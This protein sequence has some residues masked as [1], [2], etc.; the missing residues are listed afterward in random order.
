MADS[1][2]GKE[3]INLRQVIELME[4]TLT[5]VNCD[6]PICLIRRNYALKNILFD[7]QRH[8]LDHVE[9]YTLADLAEPAVSIASPLNRRKRA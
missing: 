4:A 5:P 9:R 7:A 6:E 3:A 8:F 2:W 1:G